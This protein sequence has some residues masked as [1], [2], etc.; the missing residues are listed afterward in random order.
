MNQHIK[1]LFEKQYAQEL[2]HIAEGDLDSAKTLFVGAGRKENIVYMC[3]QV[4]EKAIKSVLVHNQIAF[5]LI[6]DLG[7]LIGLMPDQIMPPGGFNLIEL[8]PFAS[9]RRYEEGTLPLL[10]EEIDAAISAASQVIIWANKE[11]QK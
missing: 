8:N 9:V 4:V 3:Q 6:H 2:F 1:R 11:I 10:P 7:A 5:P